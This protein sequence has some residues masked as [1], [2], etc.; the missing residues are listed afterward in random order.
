VDIEKRYNHFYAPT[1]SVRVGKAQKDLLQE[2]IE[3]FSVSVNSTLKGADDFSVTINNA[4]LPGANDFLNFKNNLFSIDKDNDITIKMGYGDRTALPTILSGIITGIEVS[5]PSNGISQLTIKGYDHSH[6]MMKG[7]HSDSWGSDNNPVKYSD[8]V[9]KIADKAQYKFGKSNIVDTREQHPQ[10]KQ[11]RQTDFDFIQNRLASEIR[12][13]VFVRGND[14]YFRPRANNSADVA[15]EL[16]WG[17]TLVSF[18]PKLNTAEQISEVQVRGWDPSTQ[19]AIVGKARHGAEH[20]RDPGREGGGDAV[21]ATQGNVVRHLWRPVST[22]K[23]AED[24]AKSV[25]EKSALDFVTGSAE[26]LGIPDI[27][28]GKNIKL[29]GLGKTFSK[30]YYIEKATHNIS[31]S[32]YKTTFDVKENTI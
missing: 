9:K 18:S 11:D 14:L 31:A 32:G 2:S 26:S 1:F 3:I 8:V 17:R 13:E 30:T 22:E 6:K 5:F 25:L 28:P 4:M 19:K 15:A 23:E 10:V 29:S 21:T 7:Q 16:I 20:G 12:F 24:I 27:M